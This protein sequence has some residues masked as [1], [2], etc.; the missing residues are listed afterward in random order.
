MGKHS[1]NL[2]KDTSKGL[3]HP[4]SRRCQGEKPAWEASSLAEKLKDI[5]PTGIKIVNRTTDLVGGVTVYR[6]RNGYTPLLECDGM[7][8]RPSERLII[9][10]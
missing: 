8:T 7:V 10:M 5:L 1:T 6:H 3:V 9:L 2:T 4:F